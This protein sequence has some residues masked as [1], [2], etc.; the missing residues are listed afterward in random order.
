LIRDAW[1]A[2]PARVGPQLAVAFDLNPAMV[3]V[4]LEPYVRQQLEDL[5]SERVEL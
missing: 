1:L 5:A 4:T 2:W 3:T